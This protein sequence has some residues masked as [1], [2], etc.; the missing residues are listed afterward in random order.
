M[1]P[2]VFAAVLTATANGVQTAQAYD[3]RFAKPPK[4]AP[5]GSDTQAACAKLATRTVAPDGIPLRKLGELPGAIM[6]HAVWRTVAGCPVR[7]V[8]YKGQTYYVT[9]ATPKVEKIEP[10][11]RIIP[12]DIVPPD[13]R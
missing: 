13:A 8:V 10:G 6:E 7:E 5:L 3:L 1:T 4:I 11:D 2:F 9:S 12:P